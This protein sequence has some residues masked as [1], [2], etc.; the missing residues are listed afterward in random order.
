MLRRSGIS[1]IFLCLTFCLIFAGLV[2]SQGGSAQ[3]GGVVTD[4]SG[5]L[6]PGVTMTVTNTET[7]VT[8]TAL[9]NESGAFNFASL[10][11]GSAYRISASLPGF[12]TKAITNLNLG[13]GTN[14]RQDF[15]LSVAATATTVEVHGETQ[16]PSLPLPVPLSV[17]CFQ[18]SA[19]AIFHW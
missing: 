7:S 18:R 17:M 14:S 13:A 1:S 19:C 6:L 12:Q 4:S 9:T 3:L 11:P 2:F 5:A 10:Q 16:I 8:T 15:Q